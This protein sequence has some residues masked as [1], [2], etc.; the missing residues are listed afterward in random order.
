M[1]LL[2]KQLA[3]S[4]LWFGG[5]Q[6]PATGT[7]GLQSHIHL[8]EV[9][10]ISRASSEADNENLRQCYCGGNACETDDKRDQMR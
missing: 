1:P 4:E 5:F 8:P 6:R 2:Q 7:N 10:I 3:G 9:C